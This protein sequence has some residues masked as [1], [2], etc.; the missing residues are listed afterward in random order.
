[1]SIL[2]RD[3]IIRLRELGYSPCHELFGQ[4]VR[5]LVFELLGKERENASEALSKEVEEFVHYFKTTTKRYYLACKRNFDPMM[6]KYA[7]FFDLPKIFK[8]F[9]CINDPNCPVQP[10]PRPKR[11]LVSKLFYKKDFGF[12]YLFL[13]I[14]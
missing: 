5:I 4:E 11:K 7:G 10:R 6:I 14:F 2:K 3:L 8:N 12:S 9:E 1:M 13:Y